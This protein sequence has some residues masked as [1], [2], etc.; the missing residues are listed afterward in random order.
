M[1]RREVVSTNGSEEHD[2]GARPPEFVHPWGTGTC[3]LRHT[4]LCVVSWGPE[5]TSRAMSSS[6]PTQQSVAM[7]HLLID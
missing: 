2:Y 6:R 3:V 1:H 5:L 4:V 7:E